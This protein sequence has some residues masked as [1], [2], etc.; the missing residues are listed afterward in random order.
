MFD[1]ISFSF[2]SSLSTNS[3]GFSKIYLF[4]DIKKKILIANNLED[5]AQSKN[6]KSLIIL[7]DYSYDEGAMKIIAEKKNLCFLIDIGQM[8]SSSGMRRA[9]L[10]AKLRN[11]LKLA[12]KQGAFYAFASFAKK[13]NEIRSAQELIHIGM[14]LGINEGQAKFAFRMIGEY[15]Q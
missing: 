4:E 8:I 2:N 11:F 14:L 5:A 6:K 1:I 3:L 9:V 12:N 7:K 10:I 13:E 15:V